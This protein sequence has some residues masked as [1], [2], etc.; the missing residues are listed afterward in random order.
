MP[1]VP[2]ATQSDSEGQETSKNAGRPGTLA[3]IQSRAWVG[4]VERTTLPSPSTA[5]Q[6]EASGH[7]TP[8]SSAP[9]VNGR[10]RSIGFADDHESDVDACDCEAEL[11]ETATTPIARNDTI[12]PRAASRLCAHSLI[13][14]PG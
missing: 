10:S 13:V 1:P 9:A 8:R 11:S 5:T 4:C 3:T 6:S 12:R 2:T 7:E 14:Q